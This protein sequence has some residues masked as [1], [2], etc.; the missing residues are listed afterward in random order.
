[1]IS[2]QSTLNPPQPSGSRLSTLDS[3]LSTHM[4][5]P[6]PK[7]AP[8]RNGSVEGAAVVAVG[9]AP[10]SPQAAPIIARAASGRKSHF[11]AATV[12]LILI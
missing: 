12:L 11:M 2:N 3:R 7:P 5:A 10:E 1:M 6:I 9:A 4:I 8:A